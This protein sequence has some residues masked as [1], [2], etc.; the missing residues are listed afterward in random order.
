MIEMIIG[1]ALIIAGGMGM[2][3]LSEQ[4]DDYMQNHNHPSQL[5]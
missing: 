3:S 5:D 1:V 2:L 4:V